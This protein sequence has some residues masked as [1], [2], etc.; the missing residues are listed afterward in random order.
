MLL[1]SLLPYQFLMIPTGWIEVVKLCILYASTHSSDIYRLHLGTDLFLCL[2][3]MGGRKEKF[4]LFYKISPTL[5]KYRIYVVSCIL[6]LTSYIHVWF[7]PTTLDEVERGVAIALILCH[8][9]RQFRVTINV[10]YLWQS[11]GTTWWCQEHISWSSRFW[12]SPYPQ[13]FVALETSVLTS[14]CVW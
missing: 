4:W 14:V 8:L 7:E 6:V 10:T 5:G 2:S 9:C 3:V 1:S 11:P 12:R 13:V